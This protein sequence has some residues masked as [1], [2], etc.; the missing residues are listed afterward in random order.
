MKCVKFYKNEKKKKEYIKRNRERYYYPSRDT[1]YNNRNSWS[2]HDIIRVMKH[3]IPDK[4]LA[5][6]IGRS[7]SSIQI[8]RSKNKGNFLGL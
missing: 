3:E 6:E 7:V 2:Q 5:K 4:E 8:I 1:A